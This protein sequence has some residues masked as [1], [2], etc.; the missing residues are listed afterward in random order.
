MV[1]AQYW[2]NPKS[3]DM[4]QQS[5]A[6]YHSLPVSKLIWGLDAYVHFGAFGPFWRT[7]KWA[8]WIFVWLMVFNLSLIIVFQFR[9]VDVVVVIDIDCPACRWFRCC[10]IIVQLTTTL[11]REVMQSPLFVCPSIRLYALYILNRLSIDLELLH[12]SRP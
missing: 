6:A 5:T 7:Y 2:D 4:H 11:A 10:K 9:S 12:V 3:A 1:S 8:L